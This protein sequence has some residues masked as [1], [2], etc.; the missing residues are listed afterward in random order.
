[1]E[2]AKR[3]TNCMVVRGFDLKKENR[4]RHCDAASF[5]KFPQFVI[6]KNLSI[7]NLALKNE[8]VKVFLR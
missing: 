8:R 1:M 3:L 7:L 5:L 4:N 2:V 6:L